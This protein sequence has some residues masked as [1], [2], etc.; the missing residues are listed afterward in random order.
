[1]ENMNKEKMLKKS[2]SYKTISKVFKWLSVGL[3]VA[4]VIA[5]VAVGAVAGATVGIATFFGCGLFGF[6]CYLSS[7]TAEAQ[8]FSLSSKT[9]VSEQ[10][11]TDVN[12]L[13]KISINT[14]EKH[15]TLEQEKYHTVDVDNE[16]GYVTP[17]LESKEVVDSNGNKC[18]TVP[19]DGK[20]DVKYNITLEK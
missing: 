16:N 13:N 10:P 20:E 18:Y 5:G 1:M 14:M 11:M 15:E 17:K 19:V 4:A 12:D 6:A 9:K 3:A 2:K 7:I 8:S